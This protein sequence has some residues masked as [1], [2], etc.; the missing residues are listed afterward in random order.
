VGR[1][2]YEIVMREKKIED[3]F[4]LEH[5]KYMNSDLNISQKE[6]RGEQCER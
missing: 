1:P 5:G 2:N 4:Y 6:R 3:N